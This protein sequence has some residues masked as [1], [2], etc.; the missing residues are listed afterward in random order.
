MMF[1]TAD[2][3]MKYGGVVYSVSAKAIEDE[4]LRYT[5]RFRRYSSKSAF[6]VNK[7]NT[8]PEN[9]GDESS[10]EYIETEVDG[11]QMLLDAAAETESYPSEEEDPEH[12]KYK[13][14]EELV[15]LVGEDALLEMLSR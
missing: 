7:E 2:E 11:I 15:N 13:A 8:P 10:S 3:I 1:E 12:R 14:I 9:E 4:F 5:R 6:Y